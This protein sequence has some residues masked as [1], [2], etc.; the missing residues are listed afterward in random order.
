MI[1]ESKEEIFI[2]NVFRHFG[3]ELEKIGEGEPKSPDYVTSDGRYKILLEL[4]TKNESKEIKDNR[5]EVLDTGE[6]Y[7][8]TTPL[9]RNN[10][11]SKL[12]S[13][14]AKQLLVKKQDEGADFCIVILHT[15]GIATSYHLSQFESSVYGSVSLIAYRLPSEPLKNC[16]YFHNSDFYA[17]RDIIDGAILVG[18]NSLQFC[19]NDLSP[20]YEAVKESEFVKAFSTGVVDPIVKEAEGR[21]YSVRSD[22]NRNDEESVIDHIREKYS[23]DKVTPFNFCHQM[24]ISRIDTHE[25]DLDEEESSDR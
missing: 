14:A 16:Y 22:V 13:K 2:R 12:V 10:R 5:S 7:L 17:H 25:I 15:S 20:R 6:V 3:F 11:I 4:K 1:K 24:L 23:I 9:T 21:A 19:I 8:K 18:E